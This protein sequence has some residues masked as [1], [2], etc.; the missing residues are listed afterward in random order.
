[1]ATR[2]LETTTTFTQTMPSDSLWVVTVFNGP[3]TNAAFAVPGI[4][5]QAS[6][7]KLASDLL[8]RHFHAAVVTQQGA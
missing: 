6:A 3:L 4:D 2:Q 1:M 8:A 5:T 7:N